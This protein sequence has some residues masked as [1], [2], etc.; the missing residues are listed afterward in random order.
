MVQLKYLKVSESYCLSA[1][2]TLGNLLLSVGQLHAPCMYVYPKKEEKKHNNNISITNSRITRAR[3]RKIR[4][5]WNVIDQNI[6]Y[7][8]KQTQNTMEQ[9][10]RRQKSVQEAEMRLKLETRWTAPDLDLFETIV[11][12]LFIINRRF[13]I[14]D[15]FRTTRN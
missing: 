2:F 6:P 3:E 4:G 10:K 12:E 11:F 8:D 1:N 13:L 15:L 9:T 7:I 14:F 5:K